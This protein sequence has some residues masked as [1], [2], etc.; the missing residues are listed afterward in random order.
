MSAVP[1]DRTARAGNNLRYE[2]I[3]ESCS[4]GE[5]YARSASEAAWRGDY[6]TLDVHL[7][8]LLRRDNQ[9]ENRPTIRMRIRRR[10]DIEGRA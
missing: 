5:S 7:R 6:R 3:V 10:G 2:F 4:L 9:D 8:Q 1:S